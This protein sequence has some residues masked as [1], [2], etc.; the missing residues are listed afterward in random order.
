[1]Y[2]V[3]SD[4]LQEFDQV[5][6]KTEF[7]TLNGPSLKE[8]ISILKNKYKIRL[9]EDELLEKY[10]NLLAKSYQ[11]VKPFQESFSILQYLKEK[12]YELALVSSASKK[13]VKN[14][15]NKNNWN[16]FFS[17][18]V[19]GDDIKKSKPS[20]EIYNLCLSRCNVNAEKILVIEDSK[21]GYISAKNAGL[22]CILLDNNIN[23]K[24]LKSIC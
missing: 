6:T 11:K 10:N 20:P 14:I 4:F 1:M 7:E 23:L 15:L 5:G 16:E 24:S 3:Y 17:L 8:I 9:S 12:N 13:V 18:V 19:T 22:D 21:N 2:D